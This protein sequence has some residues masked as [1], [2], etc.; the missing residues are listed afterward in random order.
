[1]QGHPKIT[2]LPVDVPALVRFQEPRADERLANRGAARERLLGD[3]P[4]PGDISL[5]S[6]AQ[7][8]VALQGTGPADRCVLQAVDDLALFFSCATHGPTLC[9]A[10]RVLR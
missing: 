1:M 7:R 2:Q 8:P 3:V 5:Q 10:R 9:A 6:L 4:A